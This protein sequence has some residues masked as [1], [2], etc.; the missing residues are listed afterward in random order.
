MTTPNP[1]PRSSVA[2]AIALLSH[3]GF[4]TKPYTAAERVGHWLDD[5]EANWIRFAIIEALYQGRYKS[6]S[7][8]HILSMWLRRGQPSQH[9]NGDFERIICRKLP[10]WFQ[11][12]GA[13]LIVAQDEEPAVDIRAAEEAEVLEP[14]PDEQSVRNDRQRRRLRVLG[15]ARWRW[16]A[17][18]GTTTYSQA[19]I[20]RLKAIAVILPE[21]LQAD[22]NAEAVTESIV[23]P[24]APD[25]VAVVARTETELEPLASPTAQ[26]DAL[27]EVEMAADVV[28]LDVDSV[29]VA[30]EQSPKTDS[31]AAPTVELPRTEPLPPF[32]RSGI[33]TF[34]PSL[35]ISPFFIRLKAFRAVIAMMPEPAAVELPPVTASRPAAPQ[36]IKGESTLADSVPESESSEG[37][38]AQ[39]PMITK[40]ESDARQAEIEETAALV[41]Q[42]LGA[43][44]QSPFDELAVLRNH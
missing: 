10:A 12:T 29:M 16:I 31:E 3:Y 43:E 20:K 17:Q 35:R 39:A 8:E 2:Q 11:N 41:V 32:A 26:S 27:V 5:Y 33:R 38:A 15:I 28:V 7:V 19:L 42:S 23:S 22:L 21:Q 24:T 1:A 9:F 13:A 37:H 25:P 14:V 36:S 40:T 6:I 44:E 18:Q 4:D 30:A 34:I